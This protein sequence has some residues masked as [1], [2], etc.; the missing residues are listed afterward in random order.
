MSALAGE[1]AAR[2]APLDAI[3]LLEAQAAADAGVTHSP[4]GATPWLYLS[5]D[6]AASIPAQHRVLVAAAVL[7]GDRR[8]D[9]AG[10]PFVRPATSSLPMMAAQ[11]L[12]DNIERTPL[13]A[14]TLVQVLRATELPPIARPARRVGV[15]DPAGGP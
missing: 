14:M 1:I 11:A 4:L 9:P 12:I 7:P 2:R 10:N 8:G 6:A 13:A 15:R 5:L 3:A